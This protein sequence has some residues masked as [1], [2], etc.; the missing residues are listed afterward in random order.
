[1]SKDSDVTITL[2]EAQVADVVR[3]AGSGR[4]GAP[5]MLAGATDLR[6]LKAAVLRLLSLDD[7]SYSRV[8][9][10]AILT[11]AAFPSDGSARSL[12]DVAADAGLS[13]T[14]AHRIVTTWVAVGEL[15]QEP[16]SRRYRRPTARRPPR[17]ARPR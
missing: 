16:R 7:A 13:P 17:G 2:S 10:R 14:T 8:L 1:M 15:E 4:G 11:L 3:E 12:R 6:E 9:L 5:A